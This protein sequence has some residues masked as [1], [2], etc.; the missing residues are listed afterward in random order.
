M[1]GKAGGEENE[2]YRKFTHYGPILRKMCKPEHF[3]L[4]AQANEKVE[5]HEAESLVDDGSLQPENPHARPLP[6]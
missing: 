5:E 4:L 2:S 3:W 6:W 1:D